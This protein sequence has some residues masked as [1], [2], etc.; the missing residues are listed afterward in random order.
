MP[1]N[2][3]VRHFAF[4]TGREVYPE[5]RRRKSGRGNFKNPQRKL[6]V[7]CVYELGEKFILNVEKG[8]IEVNLKSLVIIKF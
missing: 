1:Y 4:K 6:W 2:I 7:F 3:V 5:R 8:I